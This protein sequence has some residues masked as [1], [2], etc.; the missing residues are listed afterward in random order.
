M[1]VGIF[2]L[3]I[4]ICIGLIYIGHKYFDRGELYLLAVLYSTIS[5]L[6]SF[7]TINVFGMDINSSIIFSSG[8]M[9]LLYYFV[10]KYSKKYAYKMIATS[11][12]S[13]VSL[14]IFMI[15]SAIIVPSI[16]DTFTIDYQYMV[17]ENIPILVLYPISLFIT[18]LLSSYC[19]LELKPVKKNKTFKTI[20]TII[21][22]V[23]VDVFVF[24]YFS[25][26]FLIDFK[27]SLGISIENYLLKVFIEIVF[28]LLLNV[29]FKVKKVKS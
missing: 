2:L 16:F 17:L 27:N 22:L 7:K 20:I 23:F 19:F 21:G 3:L 29:I 14:I 8:L 11:M 6:M 1:S 5:F 15:I 24:I 28:V 26:T 10:N 25:Y 18:L 12:V 4:I 13:T 9:M